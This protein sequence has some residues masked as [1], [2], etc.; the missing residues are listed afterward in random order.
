MLFAGEKAATPVKPST[1]IQPGK[2]GASSAAKDCQ[3]MRA[4]AP[5]VDFR[6]GILHGLADG[7][8]ETNS[9]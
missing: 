5:V 3:S 9:C 8:P 7:K 6:V 1:L 2:T 4:S